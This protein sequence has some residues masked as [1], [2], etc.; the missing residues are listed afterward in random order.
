M[1]RPS[2]ALCYKSVTMPSFVVLQTLKTIVDLQIYLY[3]KT[4]A[5]NAVA[6]ECA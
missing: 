5:S 6:N 1:K 3:T 4:D 2:T